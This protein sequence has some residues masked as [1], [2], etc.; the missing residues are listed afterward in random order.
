MHSAESSMTRPSLRLDMTDAELREWLL[1][2]CRGHG[3]A[4]WSPAAW[5]NPP[6]ATALMGKH[7]C[8]A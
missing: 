5:C 3:G 2:F 6:S 8:A 7:R 4:T 1:S